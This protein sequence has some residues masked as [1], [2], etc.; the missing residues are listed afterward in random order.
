MIR[1]HLKICVLKELKEQP[2]SGYR[3]MKQLKEE[4]GFKPSPGSM[5]PLLENLSNEGYISG[6]VNGRKKQYS[7]TPK[8]SEFLKEFDE[9]RRE[10]V[11][12]FRRMHQFLNVSGTG[13]GELRSISVLFGQD[14]APIKNFRPEL[15]VFLN[16][17][18]DKAM[19][20]K[21]KTN[22][23]KNILKDG[24]RNLKKI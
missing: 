23:I 1:G 18:A 14:A 4:L 9:T 15:M 5:Y 10:L 12:K 2:M 11:D 22:E 19:Q 6:T 20:P 21:T 17:I 24:I 8:G 13:H 7:L 3:L 16:L